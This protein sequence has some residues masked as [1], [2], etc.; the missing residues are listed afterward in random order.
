MENPPMVP[1]VDVSRPHMARIYD[2]FLGGK[3]H[4]AA[5]RA[6]AEK[7]LQT[8]PAIRIAAREN[9][10][11]LGRSIR[12]LAAEAGIRQFLDIGTGTPICGN[13]GRSSTIRGSARCSTSASRRRWSC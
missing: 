8:N 13:R 10:A 1:D 9:R 7:I 4:F 6:T 5:D 12:Y 3:N 2:Y 11:F